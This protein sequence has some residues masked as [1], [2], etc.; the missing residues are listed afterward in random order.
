MKLQ[1]LCI[2]DGII[3]NFS[4]DRT[5]LVVVFKDFSG[6]LFNITFEGCFLIKETG[7]VGFSLC[8]AEILKNTWI[9]HD[10]DGPVLTVGFEE[11]DIAELG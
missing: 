8:K 3:E 5:T 2:G 6:S 4:F 7:S 11:V 9:V 10:D 1:N